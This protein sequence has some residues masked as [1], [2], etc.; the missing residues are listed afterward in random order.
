MSYSINLL[1]NKPLCELV[2]GDANKDREDASYQ[3][4]VVGHS[5]MTRATA[6]AETAGKLTLAIAQVTTLTAII[7]TL[8]EASQEERELEKRKF[9][10]ERDRLLDQQKREGVRDLL[11]RERRV[12][13]LTQEIA[14]IDEFVVLVEAHKDTLA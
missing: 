2:V 1:T 3:L 6:A 14:D 9:E 8:P 7:P 13:N 11:A 10:R 12:K 5:Q 4:T